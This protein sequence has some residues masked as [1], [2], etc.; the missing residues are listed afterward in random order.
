MRSILK[1]QEENA[2]QHS[3]ANMHAFLSS[4]AL[5]FKIPEIPS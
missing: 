1:S 4:I 5:N 2:N 3:H